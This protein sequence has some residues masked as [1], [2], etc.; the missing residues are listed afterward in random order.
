MG[1]KLLIFLIVIA[2]LF[3]GYTK[4]I[5]MITFEKGLIAQWSLVESEYRHKSDV[6]F[7]ISKNI[8]TN[9]NEDLELFEQVRMARNTAAKI[10]IDPAKIS[11]VNLNEYRL[12]FKKLL[13]LQAQLE[14]IGRE[15]SKISDSQEYR[16][17]LAELDGTEI[18]IANERRRLNEQVELYNKYINGFFNLAIAQV[19]GFKEWP[20]FTPILGE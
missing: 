12:A 20:V 5:R 19:F 4:Y 6:I 10:K 18:R 8:E 3:V 7:D 17:L 16:E 15:H 2:L 14:Q 13:E 1:K 9:I 11:E